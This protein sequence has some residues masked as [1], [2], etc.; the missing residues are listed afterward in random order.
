MPPRTRL[1]PTLQRNS[2]LVT[3]SDTRL[4]KLYYVMKPIQY[5]YWRKLTKATCYLTL[6]KALSS[7]SPGKKVYEFVDGKPTGKFWE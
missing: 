7:L 1:T 4:P 3:D 6:E 2:L 5:A